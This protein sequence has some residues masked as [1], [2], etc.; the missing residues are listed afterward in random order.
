MDGKKKWIRYDRESGGVELGVG[1]ARPIIVLLAM[2]GGLIVLSQSFYIV[3]AGH[4]AVEFSAI[5][6]VKQG[7]EQPGMHFK[8]PIL[9]TRT[10]Y[11]TQKNLYSVDA[12]AASKDGQYVHTTVGVG[13][14]PDPVY[15]NWLHQNIGPGYANIIIAPAVQE[16]VKAATAHH[17]ALNL[18]RNRSV[19]SFEIRSILLERLAHNHILM[20]EL[21]ITNFDYSE[22][23]NRALERKVTAEQD[24]EAALNKLK[25]VEY[26]AQQKVAEARGQAEAS[27]LLSESMKGQGGDAYLFLQW[28]L[29]WDGKLPLYYA[30]GNGNQSVMLPIPNGG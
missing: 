24:A 18:I 13:Y 5:S 23:F 27:V 9:E 2:L 19:V 26:E 3:P 22:E 11:R 21:S 7:T 4:S 28:L 12:D 10:L 14:H 1:K 20:D 6:G 16:A 17:D 8:I 25:Q 30:P 15:V 29:K